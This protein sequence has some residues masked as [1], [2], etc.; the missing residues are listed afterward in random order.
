MTLDAHECLSPG[1]SPDGGRVQWCPVMEGT[2]AWESNE[3]YRDGITG[4]RLDAGD[5]RRA[6]QTEVEYYRSVQVYEKM[7]LT[8]CYL[9]TGRVP[10]G[11]RWFDVQ[12]QWPKKPSCTTTRFAGTPPLEALKCFL[13]KL[14]CNDTNVMGHVAVSKAYF[15]SAASRTL[16]GRIVQGGSGNGR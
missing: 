4:Q 9:A 14:S 5:V 12:H 10:F 3:E 16:H 6:R 13:S 7:P 2:R 15:H 1:G 11:V 8:G